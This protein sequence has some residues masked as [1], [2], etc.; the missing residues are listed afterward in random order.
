MTVSGI[1]SA[2]IV[3]LVV[4]ALARLVL[5]GK[6]NISIVLT[7]LIGLVAAFIGGFIG[8]AIGTNGDGFSFITLII[9]VILAV[10]GVSIV[11][12]TQGR[13]SVRR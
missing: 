13:K 12:G 2:I 5:P 1:I 3:G 6:Q 10:I 8:N 7:I 4:G 9:Q 11:A